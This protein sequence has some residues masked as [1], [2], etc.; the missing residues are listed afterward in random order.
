MHSE[1]SLDPIYNTSNLKIFCCFSCLRKVF[2]LTALQNIPKCVNCTCTL[3]NCTCIICI[4]YTCFFNYGLICAFSSKEILIFGENVKFIA[5]NLGRNIAYKTTDTIERKLIDK[6][7]SS[8]IGMTYIAVLAFL[9]DAYK[10]NEKLPCL[11]FT[12]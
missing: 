12:Q 10:C 6:F 1:V 3:H 7:Q 5:S 4:L 11:F 8:V 9:C 2:V